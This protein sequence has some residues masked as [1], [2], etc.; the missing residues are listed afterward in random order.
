[1]TIPP[2]IN[3]FT[4]AFLLA[5]FLI[6][7]VSDSAGAQ[8][9]GRSPHTT[10]NSAKEPIRVAVLPFRNALGRKADADDLSVLGDGIA[11]SVS[12]AL[13]SVAG[14]TVTDSELVQKG[15]ANF[16][17]SDIVSHDSDALRVAESLSV[18]FAVAGS[19]Q[20]MAGQ[21]HIDARILAVGSTKPV[22]AKTLTVDA[23][24]PSEYSQ[25]LKKL[26]SALISKLKVS[27]SKIETENIESVLDGMKSQQAYRLYSR[28]EKERM[29]GTPESLTQAIKLYDES[30]RKDPGF[31]LAMAAKADAQAEL[32]KFEK[33]QGGR[34]DALA[35][36][37]LQNAQAAVNASPHLGR[38]YLS[39][40]AA[41][42]ALGN[43]D[44]AM[45]AANQ[46]RN[47]WPNDAR[48]YLLMA[49]LIGKGRLIR[50]ADTDRAFLL[51][52]GLALLFPELPKVL[53]SN[54]T[55]YTLVLKFT[56]SEG[57][58]YP[59]VV[60][61]PQASRI[62]P[63][64]PGPHS[65]SI[66]G[67]IGTLQ[68]QYVFEEAQDYKLDLSAKSLSLAS[69][70]FVNGGAAQLSLTV[71]GPT[72][73][74]LRLSPQETRELEALPGSYTTTARIPGAVRTDQYELPQGGHERVEYRYSG[75]VFDPAKLQ[76]ENLGNAP[77]TL[78][79]KGKQSYTF[80]IP[81]GGKS[82][83]LSAGEYEIYASCGGH[84]SETDSYNLDPGSTTSIDRYGCQLVYR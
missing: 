14:L 37:A 45:R 16:P 75:R 55:N 6:M 82:V 54:N 33:A 57:Q 34:A 1:M 46:A 17:D 61:R 15:M 44:A 2:F 50:T 29:M 60:V 76:V 28:G 72:K 70:T 52:P 41:H 48:N 63:L 7:A 71:S 81:P 68:Q 27:A 26:A 13:K 20:V 66:E 74:V 10:Q 12:N 73:R 69:F 65:M 22:A 58:A 19:F 31:A 40:A 67:E 77:F 36:A 49:K 79:A 38:G 5:L 43:V 8:F 9:A 42:T 11:D 78:W 30:L 53:I 47:A 21:I 25:L 18:Q 51:Q 35:N 59:P 56:P 24:Y 4:A 3:R 23:N 39:Q 64:F 83:T 84:S 62:V 80:N 32:C